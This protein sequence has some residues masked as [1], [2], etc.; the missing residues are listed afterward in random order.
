MRWGGDG[1]GLAGGEVAAREG[2]AASERG[3]LPWLRGVP[4]ML[5]VDECREAWPR[6]LP[7][8]ILLLPWSMLPLLLAMDCRHERMRSDEGWL[9][10]DRMESRRECLLLRVAEE[11]VRPSILRL[12][13]ASL[14]LLLRWRLAYAQSWRNT[15]MRPI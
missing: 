2:V 5:F 12:K 3:W 7:G 4:R 8:E 9:L 14:W 10:D 13:L 11:L 1:F 15:L 6:D